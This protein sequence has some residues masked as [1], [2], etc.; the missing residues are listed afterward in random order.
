MGI[1]ELRPVLGDVVDAAYY[2]G[3]ATVVT[4]KARPRAAIVP[5]AWLA[6]LAAYREKYGPLP[7][8]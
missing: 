2:Q 1:V 6:E 5:H 3:T 7:T 8:A 4:K